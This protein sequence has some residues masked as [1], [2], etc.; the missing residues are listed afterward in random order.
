MC[1]AALAALLQLSGETRD[2]ALIAL[3]DSEEIGSN[4]LNGAAAPF[5]RDTFSRIARFGDK[6]SDTLERTLA[7]S[8]CISADG[9][10]AIHP[11]YAEYHDNQHAIHLNR[12]P[13]IKTN[14]NQRYATTGETATV[15]RTLA[16]EVEV[17]IQNYVHRTDLPCG[18]TIGPITAT[19]M[20]LRVVDVGNPMLSMHSIR[21]T[22]GTT[23]H[24][25]MIKVLSHF[26]SRP[27]DSLF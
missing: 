13:V 24:D 17:P 14:A 4:T 9:A 8:F 2:T 1:H 10:H 26:L 7:R 12:G 11:N 15:F 22:A 21:E 5:I 3:F 19:N 18:S 6:R 23:D 20:G 25:L 27:S 16:A